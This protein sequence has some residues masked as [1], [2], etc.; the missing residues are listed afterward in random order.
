MNSE[1]KA[2]IISDIGHHR[3][4]HSIRVKD[5]AI[6]LAEIYG[7][8]REKAETAALFHDCAKIRDSEV[9]IKKAEE[10]GLELDEYMIE[11]HELIHA[12]LG[13]KMAEDLYG[14]SDRDVLNAIAYHT[15]GSEDMTILD[16][17]IYISDY[18]EP[19][20]NFP[21]VEEVRAMAFEDIDQAVFMALNKT[22]VLL[23]NQ[24]KLI[25]VNTVLARN[26]LK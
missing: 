20:R 23:I 4:K 11:T 19:M 15:T 10:F 16:K 5:T 3:F 1:T 26:K 21:G 25:E 18:I 22:I 6:K 13:A 2:K 7:A 14:I 17:I 9:L 8:D 24:N 12:P